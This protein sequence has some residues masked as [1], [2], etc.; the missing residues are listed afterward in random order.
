MNPLNVI[1]AA[2]GICMLSRADHPPRGHDR[3]L[4]ALRGI[5]Y[6]MG[7]WGTSLSLIDLTSLRQ[8]A[9]ELAK[10]PLYLK[11]SGG[12]G[13]ID[14]LD[15]ERAVDTPDY[16]HAVGTHDMRLVAGRAALYLET[17]FPITLPTITDARSEAE[18]KQIEASAR[19]QYDAYR[20][21]IMAAVEEFKVGAD[22]QALAHRHRDA[23]YAGVP[24][25]HHEYQFFPAGAH[26][27]KQMLHEFFPI[28]K[29][30]TDLETIMG[31]KAK[32]YEPE[33]KERASSE[34]VTGV[35]E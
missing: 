30:L 4:A 1:I 17:V 31:G 33:L 18:L 2:A 12:P 9:N 22:I 20:A 29:T 14:A 24:A 34:G 3:D 23:I 7:D 26:A 32:A 19:T 6:V 27:F 16:H 10:S 15:D 28:G 25:E 5:D 11:L 13:M 21:G 8:S 35:F